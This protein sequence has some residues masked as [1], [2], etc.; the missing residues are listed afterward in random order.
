MKKLKKLLNWLDSLFE[1]PL[2]QKPFDYEG[3]MK[4]HARCGG[5]VKIS[6]KQTD[7]GNMQIVSRETLEVDNGQKT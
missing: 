7:A 6:Q 4:D 2:E 5:Y 1:V 3:P